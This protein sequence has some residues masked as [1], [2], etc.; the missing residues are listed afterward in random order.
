MYLILHCI[1]MILPLSHFGRAGGKGDWGSLGSA[2]G[3]GTDGSS[4]GG[5]AAA[6]APQEQDGGGGSSSGGAFARRASNIYKTD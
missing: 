4:D 1:I 2:S 3:Q 6:P 5:G